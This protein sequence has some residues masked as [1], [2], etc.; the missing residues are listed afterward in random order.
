MNLDRKRPSMIFRKRIEKCLKDIRRAYA[1]SWSSISPDGKKRKACVLRGRARCVSGKAEDYL[2]AAIYDYLKDRI[3]GLVV[4]VDLP[5]SYELNGIDAKGNR[6]KD[7]CYPDIVLARERNKKME[8]IY[9]AEI[10]MN[11]GWTRHK[12]IGKVDV[13]DS[14]GVVLRNKNGK[15]RM[16]RI[17]PIEKEIHDELLC[18]IGAKKVWSKT[19]FDEGRILAKCLTANEEIVFKLRPNLWYDLI[20][21]SSRNVQKEALQIARDRMKATNEL[22]CRMYVLS[23]AELSEKHIGESERRK[24]AEQGETLCTADVEKWGC[25]LNDLP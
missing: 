7:I 20:L 15:K 8:V 9:L 3:K 13:R 11:A 22:P 4:F 6:I 16:R 14:K 21:C 1:E 10:K 19:P 12:L 17:D 25:R 2:A 5:L 18:L 24:I 23:D